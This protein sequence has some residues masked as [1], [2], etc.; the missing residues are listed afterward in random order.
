MTRTNPTVLRLMA[1]GGVLALALSASYHIEPVGTLD[2]G[3]AEWVAA[4]MPGW[5]EWVFRPFHWLGS[6]MGMTP[7]TIGLA[8]LLLAAGRAADAVWATCSLVGVHATTGLLKEVFDR[9]GLEEPAGAQLPPA[10]SFPSGHASGA[11]V[12]FGILAVLAAERWP[13]RVR[14]LWVAVALIVVAT[15]VSRVVLNVHY[16][17][18]VPGGYSL[19]LA[20]LA[21]ALLVRERLRREPPGR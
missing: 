15:G 3:V 9:P 11:V 6:W 19:G 5:I 8:G 18:D 16:L 17:T 1:A 14:Q 12:T 7:L 21:G 13:G 20:W 4:S 10:D 2:D